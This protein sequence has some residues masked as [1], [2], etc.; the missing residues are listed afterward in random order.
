MNSRKAC[1]ALFVILFPV[2]FYIL[3]RIPP[4]PEILMT[5]EPAGSILWKDR[6]FEVVLQGF[7]I[8]AGAVSILLLVSGR[9]EEDSA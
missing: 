3:L 9:G 8:L 1:A 4:A 5:A 6:T 7:I 2:L